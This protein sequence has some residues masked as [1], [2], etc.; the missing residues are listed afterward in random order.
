MAS[1]LH[2]PRKFA[3]KVAQE[4]V[5]GVLLASAY[6][7]RIAKLR[8]QSDGCEYQL[9]SGRSAVLPSQ[10]SLANTPWLAVE[11]GRAHV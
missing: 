9:S 3:I 5:L 2:K 1:E 8:A 6:P 10:D 4:D 7:D 11:I